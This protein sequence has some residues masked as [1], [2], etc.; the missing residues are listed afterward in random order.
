MSGSIDMADGTGSMQLAST[1]AILIL[2]GGLP[3]RASRLRSS[4]RRCAGSPIQR[5]RVRVESAAVAT[6][7]SSWKRREFT[8]RP[9][10][11]EAGP[12]ARS[13]G[14]HRA[15]TRAGRVSIRTARRRQRHARRLQ[16]A[17]VSGR[18]TDGT[19]R[20]KGDLS[21]FPFEG[22]RDAEFR[23]AARVNDAALDV[24][25]PPLNANVPPKLRELGPAERHR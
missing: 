24:H 17:L 25:P 16:H 3:S 2:P 6:L 10:A 18:A 4:V 12:L 11:N 9:M 22:E 7:T 1:D 13:H 20:V 14:P 5:W 19:M 15:A 8:A 21:R 23:I